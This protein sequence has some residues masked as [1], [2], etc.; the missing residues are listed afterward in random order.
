M[1]R[2]IRVSRVLGRGGGGEVNRG[3]QVIQV[4][5]GDPGGECPKSYAVVR[6]SAEDAL[7]LRWCGG[8][9]SQLVLFKTS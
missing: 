5:Q 9:E 6:R 1:I 4:I 3:S 8:N 2:V 7:V